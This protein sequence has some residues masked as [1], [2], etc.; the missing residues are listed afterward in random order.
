[1]Y[2]MYLEPVSI[3]N[4]ES[5]VSLYLFL[6]DHFQSG[7]LPVRFGNGGSMTDLQRSIHHRVN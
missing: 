7:H 5:E 2:A 4:I 3:S 6:A 1:M